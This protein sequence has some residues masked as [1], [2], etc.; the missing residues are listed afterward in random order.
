M[1]CISDGRCIKAY[2]YCNGVEDCIDGSDEDQCSGVWLY[3]F[4]SLSLSPFIP[5]FTIWI[6]RWLSP[7]CASDTIFR[8][9]LNICQYF[10][11]H[12][13]LVHWFI[14]SIYINTRVYSLTIKFIKVTN[15]IIW[16][17]YTHTFT[18]TF[19]K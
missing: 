18:F 15:K 5:K 8:R 16:H 2:H 4:F 10:V 12:W 3:C 17:T 7:K 11:I 19:C 1:R 9:F 13:K 14:L 6:C